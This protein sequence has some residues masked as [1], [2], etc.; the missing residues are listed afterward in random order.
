MISTN[1]PAHAGADLIVRNAKVITCNAGFQIAQAVAVK[2]G[3]VCAVGGSEDVTALADQMT[4]II[5]A[6]GSAVIPGLIDGHAHMDREGLK[7]IFPSLANCWSIEEILGRIEELVKDAEP[8]AWIV[9]MP[10]GMPPYYFDVPGCLK[11]GRFP[12]RWEI[13]EVAPNNPVYIRPIWGFWRHTLPLDSVANSM[14]LELAGIGPGMSPPPETVEFETDSDRGELNGIIHE[15]AFMPIVELAYFHMMPGFTHSDRTAGLEHAMRAYNSFGTTSVYEEHGCAQELIDAYRAAHKAGSMTVRATLVYSPSWLTIGDA[16]FQPTMDRWADEIGG[17]SNGDEW[18]RV[19]GL[20]VDFGI[21]PDN[22]LRARAGPYTGWSGFCY[23]SGVSPGR[24][25]ELMI[26]AARAGIRTSAIWSYAGNDS[27]SL[28]HAELLECYEA[29]NKVVPIDGK[30]WIL[31]HLGTITPDQIRRVKD[32]GLVMT[33]HPN[34]HVYKSGHITREEIGRAN[35][36][37]ITPLRSV[38]EAGIPI[39]LSTDNVPISMFYP[40]WQAVSRYNMYSKDA[41]APDQA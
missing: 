16:D 13:D 34:R 27:E 20:Y 8:G 21:S 32:L 33:A 41:I 24:M 35:E 19:E 40:I 38:R 4:K 14:A 25:P 18:F 11:E 15:W 36:N 2:E 12:T 30:R 5:D 10:I 3:I 6:G 1:L 29:A 37:T 7:D 28:R 9:T 39:G 17:A 22:L 26:A 23:D 31:G